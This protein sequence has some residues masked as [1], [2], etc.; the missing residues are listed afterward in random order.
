MRSTF[1]IAPYFSSWF[2]SAI[3]IARHTK[4]KPRRRGRRLNVEKLEDRQLLACDAMATEACVVDRNLAVRTVVS[5]L[6]QPTIMAFLG[7][8]DFLVLE[9]ASGKVQHV[10]NGAIQST[11]L[12]LAVNSGSERGLLGIALHPDFP[13]NP[14]VYLYWTEGTTSA[15]TDVLANTPVLGNRVDRFEW[16]GSMLTQR[17]NIIRLRALQPT[18]E[19]EP[20][21]AQG[22]GNHD[23]GVIQ[24]GPDGKL[25]IFI[26]DVGRRGWMQNLVNGPYDPDDLLF[27]TD[28]SLGGPEPDD[29][30]LTG[31]ILRLNDDGS[32][33]TDNPFTDI[34][35]V[36]VAR[37]DGA[38]E[39]PSVT[40]ASRGYAAF[41]LNEEMTE[42]TF[43]ATVSGI[44]F[45]GTQTPEPDDNLT[46]AHI[47]APGARGERAGVEWGFI[48]QPF[49]DTH[50]T[51]AVV[52]P[53]PDGVGGTVISKWD[54]TE[55]NSTTLAAQLPNILAGRSYIN[56][57]TVRFPGG[58]VRGQ[59]EEN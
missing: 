42:L 45:T 47:H 59:I 18:F 36:F 9:K 13:T 20:T 1:G 14:G 48:V 8:N 25:Y 58:E 35:H 3:K 43:T 31:V 49:N 5:G 19:R 6:D 17:E 28:D 22:R 39:T 2:G 37:L 54:L 27:G 56:F 10:V 52:T 50:P 23:G 16:N 15:D 26:G 32:T 29:E 40:T 34:G 38:Q 12:D 21:P 44:D 51:D 11:V 41:F 55:G 7:N 46:A 57:H 24:F 53:Y 30:H 33:P 4:T